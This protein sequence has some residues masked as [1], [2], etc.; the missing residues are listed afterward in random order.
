MACTVTTANAAYSVVN[1]AIV[2]AAPGDVVCVP[3]GSATWTSQLNIPK[4]LTLQG[5]GIGQTNITSGLNNSNAALIQYSPGSDVPF[6]LSGFTLDGGNLSQLFGASS[7][8]DTVALTQLKVHDVRFYRGNS[9]AISTRGL[10][11]GVVYSCTFDDNYIAVWDGGVYQA[12]WDYPVT[13][14]GANYLYVEDSTFTQNVNG[15]FFSET[16]QGGRLALRHNTLTSNVGALGL[17]F[18]DAHGVNGAYS[19]GYR[20]TVASEFYNNTLRT[21]VG[22]PR[23]LFHRG[24]KGIVFNNTLTGSGYMQMTEYQGWSYCSADGYPKPTQ[25]NNTYYWN[26]TI[27]P[28]LYCAAGGCTSCCPPQYDG[29]YIQ[30]NRDYWLP[31]SGLDASKPGSPALGDTYGATDTKKVYKA[32]TA[33]VWTLVYAAYAY[34]HPLRGV[35]SSAAPTSVISRL[36][37]STASA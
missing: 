28:S 19:A 23:I 1:A 18:W 21:T 22:N 2:A 13:V 31:T 3:A 10:E 6:E 27:T 12:G 24:G 8:S 37:R 17:E 35:T 25:I 29:T 26:N 11:Y 7:P 20:G 15:A 36:S 14:G 30:L 32:E 4:G 16:G 33:G 5:A 34:P 9:R